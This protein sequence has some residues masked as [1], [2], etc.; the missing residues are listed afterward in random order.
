[1]DEIRFLGAGG[2]LGGTGIHA[3]IVAQAMEHKPHFI[4]NDGGSTD[5]GAYYLGSGKPAVS[6]ESLKHDLSIVVLAALKA[7]IPLIY[8]TAA[9]AGSDAHVDWVLELLASILEE[10]RLTAKVAAIYANQAADT[11]VSEFEAGRLVELAGAP[12]LSGDRIRGFSRIV[13]MMGVEPIQE[14]LRQGAQIVIAGRTS[15]AA[16]FAAYPIMKGYNP[17]LAWHAGKI[18]ECG[19]LACEKRGKGSM[20]ATIAG[21][22]LTITPIGPNLRVTP[23]SVA[24][25]SLY[26]NSHPYHHTEC[27]GVLDISGSVYTGAEDGRSTHISGSVFDTRPPTIKLEAAELVGHQSVVI[28]GIRDPYILDQ[29]DEFLAGGEKSILERVRNV[30]PDMVHNQDF[31]LTWHVYG[32]NGVLGAMEPNRNQVGHEVGVIIEAT[33]PTIELSAKIAGIA[34]KII[35]HH[36][37]SKWSGGITGVALLHSPSVLTRGPVYRFGINHALQTTDPVSL[38]KI[39]MRDM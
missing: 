24:S 27:G 11:I 2:S 34:R 7:G 16:L 9:T 38:F 30:F 31:H 12:Q 21:D 18:L 8:G 39:Q 15:D 19:T 5:A 14:A 33:A 23:Q 32:R 37:I 26:E 3:D 36:P 28:C 4:A 1:M 25:H 13:G 17:G 10:N 29:L 20:I 35:L 6:W 22:R